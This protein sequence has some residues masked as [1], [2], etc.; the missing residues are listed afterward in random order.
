MALAGICQLLAEAG[1]I[2]IGNKNRAAVIAALND[3]L[4]VSGQ[5]ITGQA[6]HRHLPVTF[7]D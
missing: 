6:R 3:M 7:R 1:K 2:F 5:D 4:G